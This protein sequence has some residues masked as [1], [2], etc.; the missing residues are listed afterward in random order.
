MSIAVLACQ[1]LGYHVAGNVAVEADASCLGLPHGRSTGDML[2][3]TFSVHDVVQL[4]S[5]DVA[6]LRCSMTQFDADLVL[7]GS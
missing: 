5:P 2:A 4:S 7:D 1:I 6:L 3:S